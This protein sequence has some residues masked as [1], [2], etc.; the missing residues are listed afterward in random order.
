MGQK[1]RAQQI[2]LRGVKPFMPLPIRMSSVL[3]YS[4]ASTALSGMAMPK[5][6]YWPATAT[7]D[8]V[9]L[10][11]EAQAVQLKQQ[12]NNL[13]KQQRFLEAY[14]AYS[15]SIQANPRYTDA[16]F[17]LAQLNVVMGNLPAGIQT[18]NQLLWI[19]PSDHTAR[20]LLGEY[21]ERAGNTQEAKKR[22]IEILNAKPDFDPAKRRLNYLLYL[23]QKRFYP[24]TADA[25]LKA[26]YREITTKAHELMRQYFTKHQPNP[27]LAYCADKIPLVFASTQS[28]G[29]SQNIAEYDP[30]QNVIRVEPF[31]LFSTP[32]IVAAYLVHELHHALDQD[33]LTSIREEQDAYQA[34][35]QFWSVFQG[36]ENDPNLDQALRLYRQHP[37]VLAQE[38]SR[39][40]SI[41][42]PGMPL[43]SPGH[44]EPAKSALTQLAQSFAQ[45]PRTLSAP[46]T[47]ALHQQI[48]G[49]L[50]QVGL[51]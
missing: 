51:R 15:Q 7:I 36:A 23:D 6:P 12:G 9:Q 33:G 25:L 44:G 14:Q 39:V 35:A 32:N 48:D 46:E 1:S 42:T 18:L 30:V 28:Q 40:Y 5:Q 26:Q 11:P 38:V 22:Y 10:S 3:S 27:V 49:I 47:K 45:Y 21:W 17:N 41:Q 24:E 16:Y 50:S 2:F 29:D 8:T 34:L 43:T 20:V 4:P 37:Q 31:M 13:R 19:D